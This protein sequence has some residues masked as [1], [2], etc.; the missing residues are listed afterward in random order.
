MKQ[1]ILR[2]EALGYPWASRTFLKEN[3]AHVG[4]LEY[5][6][7]I[8][9]NMHRVGA[10]HAV[11]TKSSHRSLGL[12]SE[13]I[14]HVLSW[15][16][17]R[18]ELVVLFTEI[19]KFYERLSFRAIQEYRFHLRLSH[20]K[21]SK[22]L[23]PVTIALF[24]RAFEQREPTS[25]LVW[26]KEDGTIASFNTLYATYPTFWSLH[27]SPSLDAILSFEIKDKI[28]HLY[29]VIARKLPSLDA[30]LDHLPQATHQIY[31]Y[32]SPDK[33]TNAATPEPYLYDKGHFMVHGNWK[34][35]KP[36]MISPLSR[37]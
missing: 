28:L 32:F 29:D 1:N 24:K 5:P 10:L 19:P 2:C 16:K 26:V 35:D 14:R 37:C 8:D 3:L 13:L 6:M 17:D 20:P 25:N 15:A 4:Y 12:A 11:C 34:L 30:I 23:Q 18:V 9:G 31:F 36:F 7:L 22:T 33:F 21:G 27:Y